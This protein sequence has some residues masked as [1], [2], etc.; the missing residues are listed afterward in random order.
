MITLDPELI[1]SLA[2]EPKLSTTT[3]FD[4]KPAPGTETP[5]ARLP[6]L[7]RLRVQ[8]KADESEVVDPDDTAPDGRKLTKEEKE[9]KKMRGKGKSL[10]R[11]VDLCFLLRN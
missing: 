4:R 3:T 2:P 1:G 10:K 6:R 7:A 8:G 5:F 11:S 9:R